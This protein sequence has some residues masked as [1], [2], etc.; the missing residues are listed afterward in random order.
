[1]YTCMRSR[2]RKQAGLVSTAALLLAATLSLILPTNAGATDDS[3][4]LRTQKPLEHV[5]FDLEYAASV[6]NFTL[7]GRNSMS[8]AMRHAGAEE[9]PESMVLQ[10]CQ[11]DAVRRVL[12]ADPAMIRYMPCRVAAYQDGEEVV[13]TTLLI[14]EDS[15]DEDTDAAA[16]ELNELMKQ[17]VRYGAEP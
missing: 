17:I 12:E 10:M 11:M 16:R 14:P 13:V 9:P 2:I 4:A 3:I 8:D 6:H 5:I 7:V 1:M 15:G